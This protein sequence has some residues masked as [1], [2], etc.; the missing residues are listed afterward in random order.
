MKIWNLIK[1]GK[2]HQGKGRKKRAKQ[3]EKYIK[4]PAQ[5]NHDRNF[6]QLWTNN[7]KHQTLISPKLPEATQ[8]IQNTNPTQ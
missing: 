1:R 3:H 8:T 4:E 6:T 5:K 7:L 2:K